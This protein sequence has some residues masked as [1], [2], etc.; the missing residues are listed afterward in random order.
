MSEYKKLRHTKYHCTYHIVFCPKYRI[1]I[2]KDE[3]AEYCKGQLY[4]LCHQKDLVEI[5]EL[6]IQEDHIHII[7]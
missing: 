7:V 2:F 6:N 5:L 1:R 3:I 4:N